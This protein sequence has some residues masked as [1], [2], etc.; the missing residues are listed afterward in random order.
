MSRIG[1]HNTSKHLL[2]YSLLCKE[3]DISNIMECSFIDRLFLEDF[4]PPCYC[5]GACAIMEMHNLVTP[6]LVEIKTSLIKHCNCP[7]PLINVFV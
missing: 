4:T 2:G 5:Q 6:Y 7:C 3:A 1:F